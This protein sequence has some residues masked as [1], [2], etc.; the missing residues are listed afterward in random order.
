MDREILERVFDP[1]FTTKPHGEGTGLGLSVAHGIAKSHGGAIHASSEPLKGSV[2]HVYL[3][4]PDFD[5]EQDEPPAV[6]TGPLTGGRERILVIDDEEP[7][8]ELLRLALTKLGYGVTTFNRSDEALR[9]FIESPRAYDLLITDLNM[10]GISG[11]D[12]SRQ[13]LAVRPDLP[14]ILCTG[15][16]DSL[17]EDDV[18]RAGIRS[19]AMKPLSIREMAEMIRDVL[20]RPEAL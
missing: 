3:P 4:A 10:P 11:M 5:L 2:F 1:F 9:N 19:L 18:M 16:S 12:F 13:A 7:L 8:T 20:R 15:H 17:T 14:I 6:K